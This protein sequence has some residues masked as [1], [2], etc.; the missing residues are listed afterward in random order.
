MSVRLPTLRGRRLL[1][2]E[3]VQSSAM[4]CGP[5]ALKSLLD[6][7]RIHVSYGRL[8]EACHTDIDGTSID[9]MET[10]SC[11][12]GLEA[13]Q[14]MIPRDHVLLPE[15]A[16]LPAL[17]VL[18]SPMG[19][20]HFVVIWR[21]LGPWVQIM[22]PARGRLWLTADA[23]S[24]Q[25]Y[26][27][28]TLV[29]AQAWRAW[30]GTPAFLAPLRRQL[31]GMGLSR[32]Q[33]EAQINRALSD[34][35]W[36]A[37]AVVDASARLIS[38]L[39]RD[40]AITQA[41]AGP[42]FSALVD[43]ETSDPATSAIP[44]TFWTARPSPSQDGIDRIRLEGAVL[45]RVTGLATPR[46]PDARTAPMLTS[47]PE[48]QAAIEE[49]PVRPLTYAFRLLRAD[50]LL[51]P[52]V[53]A[54]ALAV[55]VAGLLLEA[56]LLRS[57]LDV[58]LY[59][60]TV[61]QGV[62]AG[63]ALAAFAGL[64]LAL[65]FGLGSAEQRAGRRLEGRLRIAFFDKIPRLPDAYFRSRPVSDMAERGHHIHVLRV[66]PR[67]AVR[68]LRLGLELGVTTLAIAWLAPGLAG[69]AVLGAVLAVAIP[70]WGH[71]LLADRDLR[72]KTHTGALA[73]F[74]L[75]ALLGHTAIEAHGAAGTVEREH[76]QLLQEWIRASL[77]LQRGSV[78]LE[79]A[80]MLIGF[81]LVGWMVFAHVGA[82]EAG[83]TLLL[84]YWVL[85]LPALGYELSLYAREYPAH[86]SALLRL[87][88]PLGA[89]DAEPAATPGL[90]PTRSSA[91]VRL[92]AVGL[93]VKVAGSPVLEGLD[94]NIDAGS[95]IAIVGPSGAG[96][97]TLLGLVLGW[98]RP[99]AGEFLI[100]GQ[101]VSTCDLDA[102]RAETAWVDPTVRLWNQ[103][104]LDNLRYG[105][106]TPLPLAPVLETAG[107]L[108]V[109]AKLSEGLATS[110]GEGGALLSAGEAQ[111]VR[112]ARA[113]LRPNPR[114]VVLDEPF[115]GLERDRRRALLTDA[116]Q[117]WS[118]A[119]LLYV[120]HDV[121]EARSFD[122]VIVIER[123][124][125]VEDG[126]PRLLTLM[127]SSRYRRLLQ[128][129]ESVHARLNSGA[130]WRRIRVQDGRVVQVVG[131]AGIEQTA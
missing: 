66:L 41:D 54:A 117:R 59:L 22:D 19:G 75:D 95:H 58:G 90:P 14:V 32:R 46:P 88:E 127:A 56:L 84:V 45:V 89:V 52:G 34:D 61:E 70:S 99:A 116:R 29:S 103:S 118:S 13:E 55:A 27:H 71:A 120:T 98:H 81:G 53:F 110:L 42:A 57:L 112:L 100:D 121:G 47:A 96:K 7:F 39:R 125:I 18:N 113:M 40:G 37:L 101:P 131:N 97:S 78:A 114:L 124:R 31:R 8:R 26:V 63:L 25:L 28:S 126:D 50:G 65:E 3:V 64:M 106:D 38:T 104:L 108:P 91:A 62:A 23:L 44:H 48:M 72:V 60:R 74:Q 79:A 30:A 21:R 35:S 130:E 20:A 92:N 128:A 6:G 85:N 2:P 51:G 102:I 119:T 76:E 12:L 107:L 68:M 43:Q 16:N 67:L 24:N 109:I 105:C 86:R 1:A 77:S 123:G 10:L 94:L 15:A 80:Q 115:M 49:A 122:R 11:E 111:R 73:R 4:D 33:C 93:S 36:R 87:L 69:L 129:Q 17:A 5:A 82:G 83:A 9:A